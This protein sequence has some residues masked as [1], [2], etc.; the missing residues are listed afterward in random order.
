MGRTVLLLCHG[1]G[2][3]GQWRRCLQGT[4]SLFSHHEEVRLASGFGYNRARGGEEETRGRKEKKFLPLLHVQGKKKKKQCRLKTALFRFPFY[5][6]F[7]L[8]KKA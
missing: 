4:A 6:S 3:G 1:A 2:R 8:V 7:F 5:Y